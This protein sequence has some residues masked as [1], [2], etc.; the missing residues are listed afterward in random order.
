MA[1]VKRLDLGSDILL[2]A[3]TQEDVD[4][5]LQDLVSR[6]AHILSPVA[7]VGRSWVAA[8]TRPGKLSE[9][10][11]TS[12]LD[13]G[14]VEAAQK[15]RTQAALCK[16]EEVG[17]KVVITGPTQDAVYARVMDLLHEGATLVSAAEESFG[18]WI[19][20]CDTATS[21]KEGV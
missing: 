4:T 2:S 3:E 6:G 5:A 1:L 11:R 7:L 10:D 16:T 19:A 13:L 17:F 18:G 20:V 21:S 8:C 9:V 12:T 14:E 15:Q